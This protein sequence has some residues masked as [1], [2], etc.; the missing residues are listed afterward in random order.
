M[1]IKMNPAEDV[2]FRSFHYDTI[3]FFVGFPLFVIYAHPAD[4]PKKYVARVFAV[5]KPT[6]MVAIADSYQDILK[7]IP[8]ER[9]CRFGRTCIDDPCIV[10]TWF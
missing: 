3:R 8:T 4:Y 6:N 1:D 2:I 7:A 5:D 9:T 10:E